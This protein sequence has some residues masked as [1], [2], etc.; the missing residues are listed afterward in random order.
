M[1][2]ADWVFLTADQAVAV[3]E[4]ELAGADTALS[5]GRSD[6]AFDGYVRSLGLALQLGP[7]EIQLVLRRLL[8]AAS[9]LACLD[10]A[11]GLNTLGPA[12]VGVV[13]DARRAGA[14]P[15]CKVMEAWAT[16]TA[17]FGALIGEVGLALSMAPGQRGG[18]IGGSLRRA[19]VLDDATG[20]MF[21][22]TAWLSGIFAVS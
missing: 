18:T 19:A 7:A 20:T 13:A 17:D 12:I 10:G 9:K 22:L 2:S 11:V 14:V 4:H 21:G 5:A 16:A 1:R 6:S 3:L 15:S 8:E